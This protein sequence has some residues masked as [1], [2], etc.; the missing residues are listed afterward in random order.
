MKH[1][2]LE[3]KNKIFLNDLVELM[4]YGRVPMYII[5]D[6]KGRRFDIGGAQVYKNIG[7]AKTAIFT[8][9]KYMISYGHMKFLI[10]TIDNVEKQC[11]YKFDDNFINFSLLHFKKQN[12][13]WDKK[14]L[15]KLRD[16]LLDE[17]YFTIEE[18]K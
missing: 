16:Y 2:L 11:N 9:L 5:K 13:P 4:M 15:M 17:K 12:E 10:D 7:S 3:E 6:R 18:L 1:K 8:R 14:E